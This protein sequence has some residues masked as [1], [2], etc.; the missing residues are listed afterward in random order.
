MTTIKATYISKDQN[1]NDGTT[2]YW[3][4][5]NGETFGVVHG[6]ESWNAKVVDC[7]G[8]PSD[9]YTVDQFNVTEEMI[10]E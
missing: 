6:G 1:W 3:F 8:A 5:V 9:Q 10:A 4:D 2:T 7:D